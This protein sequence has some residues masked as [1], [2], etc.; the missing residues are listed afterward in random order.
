MSLKQRRENLRMSQV[1]F[2]ELCEELRLFLTKQTT[3]L[4]NPVSSKTQAAVTSY[5][6]V[7]EGRI[8]KISNSFS[9]GKATISE[10]VR[11]AAM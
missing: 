8:R 9:L 7:D 10:I 6:F 5:Y 1:S 2:F 3:R 4:R 11:R